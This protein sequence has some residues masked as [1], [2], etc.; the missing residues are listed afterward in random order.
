MDMKVYSLTSISVWVI[1]LKNYEIQIIIISNKRAIEQLVDAKMK[2]K[3]VHLLYSQRPVVREVASL[4][5]PE[6]QTIS[7]REAGGNSLCWGEQ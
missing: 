2:G 4:L 7:R 3:R 1:V 6:T 5:S